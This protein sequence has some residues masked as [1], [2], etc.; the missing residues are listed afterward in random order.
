MSRKPKKNYYVFIPIEE[1]S[2]RYLPLLENVYKLKT[3]FTLFLSIF[4]NKLIRTEG[5]VSNIQGLKATI[6]PVSEIIHGKS[7]G[8]LED[9]CERVLTDNDVLILSNINYCACFTNILEKINETD[10]SSGRFVTIKIADD[11]KDLEHINIDSQRFITDVVK[12]AIKIGRQLKR[13]DIKKEIVI[14]NVKNLKPIIKS[15]LNDISNNNLKTDSKK[16]INYFKKELSKFYEEEKINELGLYI[17][18]FR[19]KEESVELEPILDIIEDNIEYKKLKE[20]L[21]KIDIN[22]EV[23]IVEEDLSESQ[24]EKIHE[25]RKELKLREDENSDNI[26][27]FNYNEFIE[28]KKEMYE[29]LKKEDVDEDNETIESVN[30]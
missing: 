25:F 15:F 19:N 18:K 21:S 8:I 17:T 27:E 2:V 20:E 26:M 9:L 12:R 24:L 14:A 23:N 22:E 7:W 3:T 5:I 4:G 1:S 16:Y 11:D 29:E 10:F 30:I 13:D 28:S 6:I